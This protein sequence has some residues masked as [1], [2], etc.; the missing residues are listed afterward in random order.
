MEDYSVILQKHLT[1][2]NMIY[3]LQNW[4]YDILLTKLEYFGINCKAG[5]VIN[6]YLNDR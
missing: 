1:V 2:W 6:S 3:Y 4:S 5:D